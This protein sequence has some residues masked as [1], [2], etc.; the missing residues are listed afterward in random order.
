MDVNA[1]V[2]LLCK[3]KRKRGRK[4]SGQSGCKRSI[5]GFVKMPKYRYSRD[6]NLA[7]P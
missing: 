1:E 5:E 3:L 4:G 7:S 6:K 2:K